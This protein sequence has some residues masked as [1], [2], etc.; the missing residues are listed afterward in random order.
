VE[1]PAL[2]GLTR[3]EREIAEHAFRGETN[4]DIAEALVISPHTVAKH[5]EHVYGKLSIHGRRDL[6]RL[7]DTRGPAAAGPLSGKS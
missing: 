7:C 5:L 3:R 4:G 2:E 6:L 1:S